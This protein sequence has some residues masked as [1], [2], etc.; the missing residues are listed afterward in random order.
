[1]GA[2]LNK[3]FYHRA[4]IFSPIELVTMHSFP[5]VIVIR[6][7]NA[8]CIYAK[9]RITKDDGDKKKIQQAGEIISDFRVTS[10]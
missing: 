8:I 4:N 5:R 6:V 10:S 9:Q 7:P 2:C 3:N 1:M